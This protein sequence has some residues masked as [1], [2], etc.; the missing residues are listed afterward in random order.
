[1]KNKH[2]KGTPPLRPGNTV[3][4]GQVEHPTGNK[5]SWLTGAIGLDEDTRVC[6][7]RSMASELFL[8]TRL[9]P[10]IERQAQVDKRTL[11]DLLVDFKHSRRD[12]DVEFEMAQVMAR[13][14]SRFEHHLFDDTDG[15]QPFLSDSLEREMDLFTSLAELDFQGIDEEVWNRLHS[16]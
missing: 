11:V 7:A 3:L 9:F 14:L 4:D 5:S 10:L 2:G 13:I 1:M 6:Q 15:A 8:Q 16:G 12:L